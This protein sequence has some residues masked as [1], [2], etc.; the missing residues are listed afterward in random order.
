MLSN[1]THQLLTRRC[2][3]IE[4]L[5]NYHRCRRWNEDGIEVSIYRI[6]RKYGIKREAYHGSQLDGVCIRRLVAVLYALRD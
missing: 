4:K 6:S 1:D 3:L 5:K 2:M